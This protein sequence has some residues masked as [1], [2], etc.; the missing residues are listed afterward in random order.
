M[1]E[2]ISH[3]KVLI[4][5]LGHKVFEEKREAK[6]P[7]QTQECYYIKAVRGADAQGEPTSDGFV[8][9]EGSKVATS[10]T[11]SFSKSLLRLR[12][13][14][15]DKGMI[16]QQNGEFQLVEDCIF[17]SPSTAASMV[18]GRS[19]NGLQEW[20]LKGGTTLKKVETKND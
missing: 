4:S 1:E 13:D 11:S 2:F 3:S 9:F 19:A 6:S 18:L 10:T 12:N 17:S 14:L 15:I 16:V 7:E 5:T 20:K 8:V